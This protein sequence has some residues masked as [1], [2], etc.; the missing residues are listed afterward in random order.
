MQLSTFQ[1]RWDLNHNV[2]RVNED[3][4][5]LQVFKNRS[6]FVLWE[7]VSTIQVEGKFPLT[8]KKVF[9]T[10]RNAT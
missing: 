7:G 9:P 10:V 5:R 6:V 3:G 8:Y 2:C 4:Y 1:G